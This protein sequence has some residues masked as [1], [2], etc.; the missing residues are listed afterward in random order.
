MLDFLAQGAA[1]KFSNSGIYYCPDEEDVEG[2]QKYI[3]SLPANAQPE[4]FGLHENASINC[5][6]MEGKVCPRF[7]WEDSI[8]VP[9]HAVD[10]KFFLPMSDG[11][12]HCHTCFSCTCGELPCELI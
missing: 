6:Q 2:F 9:N 3:A 12:V 11:R 1:Y 8:M 7:E 4:V 10:P 5:A